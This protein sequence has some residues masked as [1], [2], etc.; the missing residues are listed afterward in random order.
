MYLLAHEIWIEPNILIIT[1]IIIRL[2]KFHLTATKQPTN[3]AEI[4]VI[5]WVSVS[6]K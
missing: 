5:I 6:Y 2:S 1:G 4:N 3:N